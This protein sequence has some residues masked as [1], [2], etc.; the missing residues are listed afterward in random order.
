MAKGTATKK[1]INAAL[2]SEEVA[3]NFKF[4]RGEYLEDFLN[5]FV[6]AAADHVFN[7]MNIDGDDEEAVQKFYDDFNNRISIKIEAK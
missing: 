7:Q 3:E 1:Q 6:Q 4:E 2:K 5:D